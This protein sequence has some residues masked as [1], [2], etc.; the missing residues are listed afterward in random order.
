MVISERTSAV[1]VTVDRPMNRHG[2]MTVEVA[3][4]NETR[5]IVEFAPGVEA[6]LSDLPP[7]TTLP[8]EMR[9]LPA[10]GS[11]WRATAV[12]ASARSR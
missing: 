6:I 1:S 9:Q 8:I 11:C 2:T 5:H 12:G 3:E 10:R 7:D 4:T